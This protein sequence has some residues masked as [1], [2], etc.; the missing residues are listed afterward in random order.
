LA[1]ELFEAKPGAE[2]L[3]AHKVLVVLA[4]MISFAPACAGEGSRAVYIP[5]CC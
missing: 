4:M 5:L 3:V 2:L 1:V